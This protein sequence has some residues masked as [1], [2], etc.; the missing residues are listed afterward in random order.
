MTNITKLAQFFDNQL[1]SDVKNVIITCDDRSGVYELFGKY[2]IDQDA[3]GV[4]VRGV[5]T[6]STLYS[7]STLKN[8]VS[9]CTLQNEGRMSDAGRLY[10]LDSKICSIEFDIAVHKK[11]LESASAQNRL[12][13]RIKLQE[14]TYKR[15]IVLKEINSYINS[16]KRL[17]DARFS[18]KPKFFGFAR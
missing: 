15:R 17:Q 16:S 7:F 8:A 1:K 5:T 2:V 11:M 9:W 13:Y 4:K 6:G 3:L 10:Y 18:K 12:I 14:D